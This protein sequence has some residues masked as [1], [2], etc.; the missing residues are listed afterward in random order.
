MSNFFCAAPWRGLHINPRGDVKTCCAGDPNML[1]NLNSN[2]IIEILN[3]DLLQ[4]IRQ[5]ISQG[6]PHKYCGN[7]VQAERLGSKSERDWHNNVNPNFDYATAGTQYHY[8]VIVNIA[9]QS[10]PASKAFRSSQVQDPTTNKYV[11]LLNNIK[12]TYMK[13]L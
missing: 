8:P 3:G 10:G 12:S 4:E 13:W 2:D 7:C 5:I 6:R 11:T 1:G 9:V